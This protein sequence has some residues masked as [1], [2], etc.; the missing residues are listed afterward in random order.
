MQKRL[1][2]NA[3]TADV[4]HCT[5]RHECSQGSGP[6]AS[7]GSGPPSKGG[8][9]VRIDDA[10]QGRRHCLR[11]LRGLVQRHPR[12]RRAQLR[13][14]WCHNQHHTWGVR[15]S[16]QIDTERVPGDSPRHWFR[17]SK[18]VMPCSTIHASKFQVMFAFV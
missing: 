1:V 10:G 18:V 17:G 16:V 14:R 15:K 9:Q 6:A 4:R 13:K 3:R 5:V 2:D 12:G 11:R 7:E 8:N